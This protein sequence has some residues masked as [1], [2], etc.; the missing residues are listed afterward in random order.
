M[1]TQNRPQSGNELRIKNG[2]AGK[3]GSLLL[4]AEKHKFPEVC[5]VIVDPV[6]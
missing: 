4:H 5:H 6:R 1:I 2:E 3:Q